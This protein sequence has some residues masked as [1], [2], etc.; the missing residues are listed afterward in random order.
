MYMI[1]IYISL[2][3]SLSLI[4]DI[5]IYKCFLRVCVW[6]CVFTNLPVYI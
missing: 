1:Y 3:L 6:V 2:S 4:Y 5:Y